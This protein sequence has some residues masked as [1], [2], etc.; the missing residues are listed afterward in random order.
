MPIPADACCDNLVNIFHDQP[1]CLCSLLSR[2]L[3]LPVNHSLVLQLPL[4]CHLGLTFN[5]NACPGLSLSPA[6]SPQPQAITGSN[7]SFPSVDVPG[8]PARASPPPLRMN[9]LL[10]GVNCGGKLRVEGASLTSAIMPLVLAGA[11]SV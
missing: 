3:S 11:L 5:S 1:G 4:L 9:N 6:A 8:F 10:L 7:A 2:S